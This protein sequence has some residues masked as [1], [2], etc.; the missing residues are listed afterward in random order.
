MAGE[1]K[2]KRVVHISAGRHHSVAVVAEGDAFAWGSN[3]CGQLGVGQV[4]K[5]APVK[6]L[7]CDC[8]AEPARSARPC[9]RRLQPTWAH[10]LGF[11]LG[12][13]C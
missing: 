3:E 6:G 12:L 4:R 5:G 2:G 9:A 11:G 8:R 1:L 10:R 7:P 13:G